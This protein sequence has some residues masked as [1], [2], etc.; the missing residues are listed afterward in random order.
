M[1]GA[2]ASTTSDWLPPSAAVRRIWLRFAC[3]G[4]PGRIEHAFREDVDHIA[5]RF[6]LDPDRLT[7]AVRR[8]ESVRRLRSAA[9]GAHGFLAAA[10]DGESQPELP[11]NPEDEP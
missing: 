6:G 5:A 3:A 8:G 10:R 4:R 2:R 11:P 7:G 9:P 1:P